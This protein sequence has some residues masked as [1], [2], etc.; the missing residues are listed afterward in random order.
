MVAKL[1]EAEVAHA[2][3]GRARLRVPD[4]RGDAAFFSSVASGLSS[5]PGVLQVETTALTG[6]ILIRHGGPLE[7]VS[8]AAQ[9]AGLFIL[10]DPAPQPA[11]AST[12][13]VDPRLLV[14]LALAGAALWQMSREKVL[15]PALTLLWYASQLGGFWGESGM[16]EGE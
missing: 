13:A 6:S 7:K 11:R 10:R 15:P 9:N 12:A 3:P 2:I 14:V 16:G 5:L 1:P 8:A 4:R